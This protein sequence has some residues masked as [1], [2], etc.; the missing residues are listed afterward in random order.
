M[1]VS[2]WMEGLV[3]G[4]LWAQLLQQQVGRDLEENVGHEKDDQ[5]GVEL[6]LLESELARQAKDI[7]I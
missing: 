1:A 2:N 7:G 4:L 3:F 6:R 5:R